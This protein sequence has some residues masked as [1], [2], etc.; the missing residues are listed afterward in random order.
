MVKRG[1][2]GGGSLLFAAVGFGHCGE[3][4]DLIV[5]W[6]RKGGRSI[7]EGLGRGQ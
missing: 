6:V 2:G 4:G 5:V 7:G 3:G 1:Q